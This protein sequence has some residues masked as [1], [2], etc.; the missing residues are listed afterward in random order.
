MRVTIFDYGAGNI[1]SLAK[2]IAAFGATVAIEP[3]PCAHSRR[4]CSC[5]PVSA[6]SGRPPS[7]S[8]RVAR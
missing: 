1:H 2:A 6:P 4:T 8:H 3:I 5:Y 7:V